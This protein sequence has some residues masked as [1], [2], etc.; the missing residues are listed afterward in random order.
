MRSAYAALI[1]CFSLALAGLHGQNPAAGIIPFESYLE[2]LRVQAAIPGMSAALV[3]DG[4][5]VWERGLGFQNQ[6]SRI[7]AT[8]DTPYPIADLSQTLAAVLLLQCAEQR[9]V[10]INAPARR[11]GAVVPEPDATV[12]QILAH[13][14]SSN[15]ETFRYDPERY[16]QLTQVVER[17]IPQPYR[18]SIAVSLL[19]RLAMKDSVPGRDLI[20]R[21]VLPEK[22]FSTDVLDRYRRVL[23]RMAIPYKVDKR[24]KLTRTELQP[25]GITAASGLVSTVR[26]LARFDAALDSDLLLLE[27]TRNAAWTHGVNAQSQPLPTGLGWFVQTYRSDQVVWHFGV[28]PNSYSSLIIKLPARHLTLILLANSDGLSA[29]FQLDAGDVTKSL[30]ATLFLRLYT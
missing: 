15:G 26:D 25:E 27:S 4:Q 6:E 20:D 30:F 1:V 7:R 17:C 2:S 13:T 8:P 5:I 18:K 28:V 11:Y 12:R 3:Q 22:L 24:G 14:S 23:E 10:E 19:E 21:T 16:S 9:L 29:P